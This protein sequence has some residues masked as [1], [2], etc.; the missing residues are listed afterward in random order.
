MEPFREL[1]Q[2]MR[3]GL[4]RKRQAILKE[5]KLT[6]ACVHCHVC[7]WSQDDFWSKDYNPVRFLLNW[8]KDLLGEKLDQPFT[9]D[10]GF[11]EENG[12]LTLREVIARE[13]EQ[14][15]EKIRSMNFM[16]EDEWHANNKCPNCG[17]RLDV[18]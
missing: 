1:L 7:E 6:E 14:A 16:S 2:N 8:E 13:C 5:R 11:I 15:A 18:D 12:N 3:L 10:A 4:H 9:D 17:S